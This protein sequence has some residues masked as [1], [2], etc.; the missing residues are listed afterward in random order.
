MT[1]AIDGRTVRHAGYG[2]SQCKRTLV[3]QAFGWTQTVGVSR[4]RRDRD[5]DRSLDQQL[6]RSAAP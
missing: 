3:E 5:G 6:S 1:D 4:N 2:V